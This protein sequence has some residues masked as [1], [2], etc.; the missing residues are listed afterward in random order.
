MMKTYDVIVVGLG[1]GGVGASLTL[2]LEKNLK[3]AVVEKE[4]VG[5]TMVIG[6]VNCFEPG[7]AIGHIQE[8]LCKNLLNK[9]LGKVQKSIEGYPCENNPYAIS[10]DYNSPYESTLRRGSLD[11]RTQCRRFM[12]DDKAMQTEI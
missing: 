2:A 1:A 11:Q 10:V 9:G 6:G 5:G 12:F 4:D 7:I 8:S 3:V